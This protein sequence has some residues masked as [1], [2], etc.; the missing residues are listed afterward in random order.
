MTLEGISQRAIKQMQAEGKRFITS[1]EASARIDHKTAMKFSPVKQEFERRTR[2][3][4]AYSADLESGRINFY[5]PT[6]FYQKVRNYFSN[7]FK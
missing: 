5:E 7:L 4:R 3:S 2:A 1:K 6:N